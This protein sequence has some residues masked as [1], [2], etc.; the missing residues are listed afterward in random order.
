[1]CNAAIAVVRS[2]HAI[3]GLFQ[4]ARKHFDDGFVVIDNQNPLGHGQPSAAPYYGRLR[5][6]SRGCMEIP[7]N[8]QKILRIS[9]DRVSENKNED[10]PSS[11][12]RE[13]TM[14]DIQLDFI[15]MPAVPSCCCLPA[16]WILRLV[17]LRRP[18]AVVARVHKDRRPDI[19]ATGNHIPRRHT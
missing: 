4:V 13:T 14:R 10:F 3:P 16:Q 1:M 2:K 19:V 15:R 8:P 12:R 9:S 6:F 7:E 11:M 17:A 5:G 18:N